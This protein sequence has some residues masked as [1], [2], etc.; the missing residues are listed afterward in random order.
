[1]VCLI[2]C[3]KDAQ[4]NVLGR[5]HKIIRGAWSN[6][7]ISEQWM[8]ADGVNIPKER[9]STQINKVSA[10][11]ASECRRENV[12]LSRGI[13]LNNTPVQKGG[14]PG[15]KII[16]SDVKSGLVLYRYRCLMNYERMCFT[17]S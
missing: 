8:T 11:L 16:I 5:L 7:E 17:E 10:N 3:T 1:M 15:V 2:Y 4:N 12:P 6:R 14:I 13:P 9:D